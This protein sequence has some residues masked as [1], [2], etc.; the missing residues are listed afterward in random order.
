[1]RVNAGR[2]LERAPLQPGPAAGIADVCTHAMPSGPGSWPI[3]QSAQRV[4]PTATSPGRQDTH[5]LARGNAE[6]VPVAHGRHVSS[7]AK[8]A[9]L[10]YPGAHGA[11]TPCT[12]SSNPGTQ[13]Q[14]C[15]LSLAR[16]RVREN[17]G[18]ALQP[19][20]GSPTAKLASSW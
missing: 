17:G 2:E 8:A 6:T 4:R 13:L 16:V 12:F 19:I 1:M 14:S 9:L 15:K 11:Q 7:R 18:H 3:A 5:A 20:S 10:K